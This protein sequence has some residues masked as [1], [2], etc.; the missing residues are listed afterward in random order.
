MFFVC[1]WFILW[2]INR[3]TLPRKVMDNVNVLQKELLLFPQF[4]IY[5]N[6]FIMLIHGGSVIPNF[7]TNYR[8]HDKFVENS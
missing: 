8:S 5:L 4:Y 2:N 6:I 7:L 1:C 3:F